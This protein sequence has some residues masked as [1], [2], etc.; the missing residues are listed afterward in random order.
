MVVE[1]S[2]TVKPVQEGIIK[3]LRVST[4][5]TVDQFFQLSEFSF[6]GW[7]VQLLVSSAIVK[8]LALE[9]NECKGVRLQG[10]FVGPTW[11]FG[12]KLLS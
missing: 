10:D 12:K 8:R 11:C 5:L 1:L 3:D 9:C 4:H 6:K 2:C 7:M